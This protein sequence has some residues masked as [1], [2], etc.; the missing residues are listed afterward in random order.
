MLLI[1]YCLVLQIHSIA[2][3]VTP[4][5]SSQH[6]KAE[7][8]TDDYG[9]DESSGE[10][11]YGSEGYDVKGQAG[12]QYEN[13]EY[14]DQA[15]CDSASRDQLS[16]DAYGDPM[17]TD[18]PYNLN[19]P[20]PKRRKVSQTLIRRLFVGTGNRHFTVLNTCDCQSIKKSKM[21]TVF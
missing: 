11:Y 9:Y 17:S 8:V 14:I 13:D 1:T 15:Y 18:P 10:V 4:T 12:Y 21:L 3:Y 16:C 19:K 6:I 20:P 7:P 5:S 2:R